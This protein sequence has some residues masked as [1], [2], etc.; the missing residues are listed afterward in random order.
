MINEYMLIN[1]YRF[2]SQE[3]WENCSYVWTWL[4]FHLSYPIPKIKRKK[5]WY[6]NMVMWGEASKGA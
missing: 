3:V 2:V 5:P 4:Y 1:E 6:I